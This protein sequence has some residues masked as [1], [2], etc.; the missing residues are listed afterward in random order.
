MWPRGIVSLRG[1]AVRPFH[2]WPSV[3]EAQFSFYI[4]AQLGKNVA[5]FKLHVFYNKFDI[6]F[7]AC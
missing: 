2:G 1:A 6:K 5:N 7:N 3:S 4:M